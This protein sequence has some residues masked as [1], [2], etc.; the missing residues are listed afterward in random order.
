MTLAGALH[1]RAVH[2]RRIRVLAAHAARLIPADAHVLDVGS[3][4][5]RLAASVLAQRRD[6]RIDGVDVLVRPETAI[7]VRPFDGRVLPLPSRSVDVVTFFDV[8]HHADDPEGLLREAARVCRSCVVIK[9]H[10]GDGRLARWLLRF[11]DD[12]GNKR[13]GVALPHTYWSAAQWGTAIDRLR[14]GRGIWERGG[15]GLY[16][17]PLNVVFGGRLH[18][19]A[20][21]DVTTGAP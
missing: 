7:P 14:L 2:P 13:H 17:F 18:V 12:V 16:P 20:R 3:G 9:D 11:M 10:V 21:L 5:G 6:L 4:D 19:L 1:G 8:L 15:L